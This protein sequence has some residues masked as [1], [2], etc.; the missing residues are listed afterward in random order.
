MNNIK[1]IV[2]P[3]ILALNAYSSARDDY[4][5]AQGVFLDANENPY[6]TLNR[7]PDPYQQKLKKLI[8]AEKELPK[9]NIFIGNGSDEII[10]L[11]RVG[12]SDGD[13]RVFPFGVGYDVNT[14]LLDGLV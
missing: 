14:R 10:D 5:K 3:N 12:V 9:E 13:R 11:A 2:R 7:Y 4:S 8:G 6:G 1:S